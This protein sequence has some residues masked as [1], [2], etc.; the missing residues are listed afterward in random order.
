MRIAHA[1]FAALA[2]FVATPALACTVCHSPTALG[3]RHLVLEHDFFRNAAA[4][5]T[6]VPLLI[7][8]IIFAARE[9]G[10]GRK[11]R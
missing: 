5:A 2:S 1:A 11:P 3:V 9:P 7:A 10:R 4:L 6:P 8:A